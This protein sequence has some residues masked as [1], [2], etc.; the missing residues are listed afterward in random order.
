MYSVSF[1]LLTAQ[2]HFCPLLSSAPLPCHS[3]VLP[4]G[5]LALPEDTRLFP[6]SR[7]LPRLL[8]PP[9]SLPCPPLA[10]PQ[11]RPPLPPELPYSVQCLPAAFCIFLPRR[12]RCMFCLL[13]VPCPGAA[14]TRHTG[15]G[16]KQQKWIL[17]PTAGSRVQ[18]LAA[19]G[20]FIRLQG[21]VFVPSPLLATPGCGGIAHLC[22][23]SH[24]LPVS[25]L[26]TAPLPHV[27]VQ[28]PL[29]F[30]TLLDQ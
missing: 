29:F 16:W 2:H 26:S 30:P 9:Q 21:A 22:P 14:L 24:E 18:E 12:G 13:A 3:S 8:P 15:G 28:V 27:C 5:L 23:S 19:W 6:T 17:R 25:S 11:P 20:F 10:S 1:L 4:Y 7:L